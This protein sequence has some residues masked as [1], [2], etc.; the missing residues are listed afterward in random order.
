M[1]A[2]KSAVRRMFEGRV[3]VQAVLDKQ[4]MV[5]YNNGGMR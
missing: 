1:V 2:M 5:E 4:C 3:R